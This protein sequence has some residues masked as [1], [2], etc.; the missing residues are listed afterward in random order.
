MPLSVFSFKSQLLAR[1]GEYL[2][3]RHNLYVMK[4]TPAWLAFKSHGMRVVMTAEC[5]CSSFFFVF[6]VDSVVEVADAQELHA[7]ELARSVKIKPKT[8]MRQGNAASAIFLES[9]RDHKSIPA[10]P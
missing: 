5:Q 2:P 4:I 8:H 10:F 3:L 9:I 7:Q 1:P 6:P